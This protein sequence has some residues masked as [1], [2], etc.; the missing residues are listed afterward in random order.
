M[1]RTALT[2]FQSRCF[3]ALSLAVAVFVPQRGVASPTPEGIAFFES[4]IRPVLVQHCYQCHSAEALHAGKLKA[5]LLVDSRSGMA[6]GGE[7]G[8]AVVPGKKDDSLLLAAL[9][10]DGFKGAQ[11]SNWTAKQGHQPSNI[12][13]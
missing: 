2:V 1:V 10:Y 7:S 9:K 12:T 8:A 11:S 13:A 5:N 4:K 6:K 3:F